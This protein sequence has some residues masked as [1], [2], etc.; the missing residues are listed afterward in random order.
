[1]SLD[2][3]RRS[4]CATGAIFVL[5]LC[6]LW[7]PMKLLEWIPAMPNFGAEMASFLVRG[8]L[9]ICYLPDF[10]WCWSG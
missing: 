5:L 1:M 10:C 9:P 4:A 6:A 3:A 8:A 7:L 2:A